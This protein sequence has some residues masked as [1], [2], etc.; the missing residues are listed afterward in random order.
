M[1][2]TITARKLMPRW[3]VIFGIALLLLGLIFT[4]WIASVKRGIS[5][6]LQAIV[7]MGVPT[8][9]AEVNPPI[10]PMAY[11][12]SAEDIYRAAC[13]FLPPGEQA[14]A[15][16]KLMTASPYAPYVRSL[17]LKV[18][19]NKTKSFYSG[20]MM[21]DLRP[22]PA[23]YHSV[24]DTLQTL[25][26]T[27][28]IIRHSQGPCIFFSDNYITTEFIRIGVK[29]HTLMTCESH[30]QM[31]DAMQLLTTA[32]TVELQNG[33][34]KQGADDLRE[35]SYYVASV[36][37]PYMYKD[38]S[39]AKTAEEERL[40]QDF[41]MRLWILAHS[42]RNDE[43][44]M[45]AIEAAAHNVSSP[46]SA[47]KQ[48][49]NDFPAILK[50]YETARQSPEAYGNLYRKTNSMPWI[51]NN[52]TAMNL[53]TRQALHEW[54]EAFESMTTHQNDLASIKTVLAV[55]QLDEAHR[56]PEGALLVSPF[57][58]EGEE[59]NFHAHKVAMYRVL[60]CG[61]DVLYEFSKTHKFPAKLPPLGDNAIDP[62]NGKP[63]N[64]HLGMGG[65]AVYSVG[66]NFTDDHTSIT[67]TV[68]PYDG[69]DIAIAF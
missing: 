43:K 5:A 3:L 14:D 52:R 11:P 46:V 56:W 50:D 2:R 38:I 13:L 69:N 66:E 47:Y 59:A 58:Q 62:F 8:T 32:G 37:F 27:L 16:H 31:D 40:K 41:L 10:T 7:E 28:D 9:Q 21:S 53:A 30:M 39:G 67:P 33:D 45:A 48:V 12:N 17:E 22:K 35:A 51:A 63:M 65:F 23:D 44:A 19:A 42:M 57:K 1:V 15:F 68:L 4:L 29:P 55:G 54:K 36:T 20:E 61:I 6:D 60:Q 49:C 18:S 26:P 25:K 64:Y 24:L 34:Y